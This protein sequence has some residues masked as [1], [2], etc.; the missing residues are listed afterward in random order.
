MGYVRNEVLD[1]NKTREVWFDFARALFSD[2]DRYCLKLLIDMSPIFK[3][4]VL[5]A[6][7]TLA[8]TVAIFIDYRHFAK[9]ACCY[10]AKI[11][12]ADI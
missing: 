8:L 3:I 1:K 10:L 12:P 5:T 7:K 11:I 9:S 4:L 2:V 6:L